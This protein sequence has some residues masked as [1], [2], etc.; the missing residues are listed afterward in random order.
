MQEKKSIQNSDDDNRNGPAENI[1]PIVGLGASAGGLEALSS[2]FSELPE[3]S[4]M[5]FIVV[6]HLKPG[7][8][9]TMPELIQKCTGTPVAAAEDGQ[10]VEPDHIYVIPPDRDISVYNGCI[11]LMEKGKKIVPLPVDLLLQSLAMDRGNK[12]AGVILS[13]TGSDGTF[14]VK[15]IKAHEGLVLVQS[16]ESA[17]Y[18]GMP[19]SAAGT[20]VV[21]LVL[22]PEEM[23]DVLIQYFHARVEKRRR[24]PL[25]H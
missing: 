8:P 23:P 4:G 15:E 11:Q 24:N 16:R 21:D 9:S 19:G 6:M 13:G 7:Q 18:D 14:G 5:A 2:F 10:T 25:K 22:A 3:K 20:G 12:S 17:G 1:F